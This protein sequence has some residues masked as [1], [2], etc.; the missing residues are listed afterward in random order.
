MKILVPLDGSPRSESVLPLTHRLA[1]RW[2]AEMLALRVVDPTAGSGAD[3]L[4]LALSQSTYQQMIEDAQEYL[5]G[6]ARSHP[7]MRTLHE[8]GA[9]GACIQEVA[10]REGCDLIVMATHGHS[11]FV[12]WLWGSVAEGVARGAVCPTLLVRSPDTPDA[13]REILI[14][15]DGS[16]PSLE[17]ARHLGRF[18]GPETRVT[19]LQCGDGANQEEL[20]RQADGRPWM[21][22]ECVA[23]PAPQGIFDWLVKNECD[24][25]AMSTHGRDG[26][27]H[28]WSGSKVE[29][30]ARQSKCPVLVFPPG[31]LN[32]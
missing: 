29:E 10:R 8:V 21:R 7:P 27:A 11:G 12:R 25:V 32:P 20:R 22:W 5:E 2:Q 3:P 17:V 23:T 30:V 9:P 13:F 24:L 1:E 26:L 4:V 18:I 14:P 19:L 28:L 16:A 15:T 31:T 6:V